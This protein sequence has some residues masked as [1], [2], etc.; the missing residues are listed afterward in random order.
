[1]KL[2]EI[3][4][5][6][7]AHLERFAADPKTATTQNTNGPRCTRYFRPSA[8]PGGARVMVIYVSYSY[9]GESS[10]TKTDALA[11]LEWLDAG[12]VGRHYEALESK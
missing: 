3:A 11:Y 4:A 8:K 7:Q 12:N 1:M 6:I 5:R 10:L 2:V 9:Q